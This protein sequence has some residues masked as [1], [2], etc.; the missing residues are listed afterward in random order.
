M[1][2]WR[3][4]RSIFAGKTLVEREKFF[5]RNSIKAYRWAARTAAQRVLV[6]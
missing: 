4:C 2:R 5:W 3:S 6:G 1:S